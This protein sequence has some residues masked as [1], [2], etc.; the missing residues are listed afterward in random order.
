MLF[1]VVLVVGLLLTTL[2]ASLALQGYVAVT[3]GIHEGHRQLSIGQFKTVEETE[4]YIETQIASF[5][6]GADATVTL[7]GNMVDTTVTIP[8]SAIDPTGLLD[9]VGVT[10]V[11]FAA[12]HR[13]EWIP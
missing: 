2:G 6:A 5:Y 3:R 9:A 10:S 8:W 12:M 13:V 4:T 7:V 1:W 11:S